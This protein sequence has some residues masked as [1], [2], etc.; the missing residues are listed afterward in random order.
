MK[1]TITADLTLARSE[2]AERLDV[3]EGLSD[4]LCEGILESMKIFIAF[5]IGAIV[6]LGLS[7]FAFPA[8]GLESALSLEGQFMDERKA[9][10]EARR[11]DTYGGDTP[12]ETLDLFIAALEKGDTDMAAKYFVVYKQEEMRGILVDTQTDL[13]AT[14]TFLRGEKVGKT[15]SEEKHRFTYANERAIVI[16]SVDIVLDSESGLWKLESL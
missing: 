12:Q 1:I 3:S 8:R 2:G 6:G 10:L 16:G 4:F 15:L 7:L 9:I 13:I 14:A 11:A 5:T